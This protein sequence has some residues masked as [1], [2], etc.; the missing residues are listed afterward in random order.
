M[1]IKIAVIAILF[2]ILIS[3]GS[4]MF[5]LVR[6]K[7]Q[8]ERMAKALTLRIGLSLGLVVLLMLAYGTGLIKPHGVHHSV[9]AHS[10]D[11]TTNTQ[12]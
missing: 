6:D 10:S 7:S 12:K 5:F 8:G 3:L 2:V 11:P 1:L 9:P 4:G